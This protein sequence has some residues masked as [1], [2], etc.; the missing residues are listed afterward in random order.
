MKPGLCK[1]A[2]YARRKSQSSQFQSTNLDL[3]KIK[4]LQE[5]I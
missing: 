5:I 1:Y 3:V 2:K 4:N